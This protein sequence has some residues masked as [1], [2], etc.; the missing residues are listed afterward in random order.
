MHGLEGKNFE[1]TEDGKV[2]VSNIADGASYNYFPINPV[3]NAN[4]KRAKS[5]SWV[6]YDE[7]MDKINGQAVQDLFDG[8]VL[9]K[10]EIEVEYTA[11]NDVQSEYGYPLQAGL[12][13]DVDA[14]YEQYLQAAKAAGLDKVREAV[15]AQVEEFLAD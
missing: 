10:S 6:N 11:L 3:G 1:F 13:E 2:D 9:D 4:F 14:A 12:V 8:F 15:A 7:M 5:D